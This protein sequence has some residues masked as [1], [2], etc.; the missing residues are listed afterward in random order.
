[1]SVFS[2]H[3]KLHNYLVLLVT[4]YYFIIINNFNMYILQEDIK[5]LVNIVMLLG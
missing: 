1:M 4:L 5:K 2:C 3:R